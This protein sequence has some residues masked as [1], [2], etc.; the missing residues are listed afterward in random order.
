MKKYIKSNSSKN[1]I[2]RIEVIFDVELTPDNSGEVA[3]AT[4]KGHYIPEGDLPPADKKTI[5]NSQVWSDYQAFIESVEDFIEACDLH[6]YYKNDSDY[7]SF[8]WSALAKDSEGN[9]LLDFTVRIRIST[10]NAHRT[11]QSQQH[12][13]EEKK[14]LAKLSKNKKVRPLSIV[15]TINDESEEYDSYMDAIVSIDE[16]IEHALEIMTRKKKG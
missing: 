6:I 8:Y 12:K 9:D 1:D 4:Y 7:N 13:K 14:E 16:K 10:H 2:T 5:V 3:A 11:S 15:V